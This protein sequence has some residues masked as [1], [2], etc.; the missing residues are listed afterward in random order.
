MFDDVEL[1]VLATKLV[2]TSCTHGD[3]VTLEEWTPVAKKP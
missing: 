1:L 2:R 3:S